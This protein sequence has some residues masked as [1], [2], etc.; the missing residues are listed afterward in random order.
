MGARGQVVC[1]KHSGGRTIAQM[2]VYL[3]SRNEKMWRSNQKQAILS[4]KEIYEIMVAAF[5]FHRP[6]AYWKNVSRIRQ[7]YNSSVPSP[8]HQSRAYVQNPKTHEVIIRE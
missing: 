6:A 3:L 4:D 1:V 7:R 8:I 5:P 2:W